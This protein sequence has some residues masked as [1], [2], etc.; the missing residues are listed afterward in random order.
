MRRRLNHS[1]RVVNIPERTLEPPEDRRQVYADC[2]ICG[3]PIKEFMDCYQFD[4][5][6]CICEACAEQAHRIEVTLD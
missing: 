2:I 5:I 6:G 4:S 1:Q 3:E